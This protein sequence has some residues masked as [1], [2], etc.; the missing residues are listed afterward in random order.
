M[1]IVPGY[2]LFTAWDGDIFGRHLKIWAWTSKLN[3]FWSF[4]GRENDAMLKAG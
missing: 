1:K 3:F 4:P 2:G